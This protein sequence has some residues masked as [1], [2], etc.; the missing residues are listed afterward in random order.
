MRKRIRELWSSFSYWWGRRSLQSRLVAAY[1]FIIL[2]PSLLVSVF[3]FRTINNTYVRDAVDKNNY[4][5]QMEKLH[6]VNQI[7]VMERAAQI[8]YSDSAV[9]SYLSNESA[10]TLG[11]LVDFNNTTFIN[12]SR[13]QLNNPG[14]EH[15]RLYSNNES[16][17][18]IWPI[19]L[20]EDRVYEEPWY[21]EALKLEERE[22]WV[23]QSNDPDVMQRYTNLL[24]EGQPKV[25]LLRAI[26]IPAGH[27][28]GMIQVDMMLNNFTPKTYTDVR[29]NQSQ[30][31]I[32]DSG[33]RL[34]TRS[35]NSFTE[36]Y[37]QLEKAITERLKHYGETGEWD[38]HYKENG[39]SFMLIHTPLERIGASL[40]NVVSM[41]DVMKHI[42]QTRNLLIG[43][44]IG[45]IFLVTLIAYVMN[46]FILKK[47]RLLTETMK[48]VRKG[49]TYTGLSIRGGGEVGELAHHFNKL[50]NTINTLVAQA[51]HKQALTKEAELRTLHNQIDAHFLYNTLEN[52]KML[53]EI[54]DQRTI[55]D[56]LTWLGGM[57]R[58]NFKWTG[59]YVKLRDEIRHIQNYIEIMNIRFEHPIH[60]ELNI[61]QVYMEVEVLKMSLQPI[62][63]N[64]VKHAWNNG[65]DEPEGRSIRI[66]VTESEGELFILIGDNG[67]GLTPERLAALHENIYAKE[68]QSTE[69]SGKGSAGYKAG[70][71]GLRNVHQRL[72]LFYGD[73]YGLELQSEPGRWTTVFMTLPKVLLTGDKR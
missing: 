6:I 38:I 5:L 12:L 36:N 59:E 70:G 51:V 20:R 1:I 69:F 46:A 53:A 33:M 32:A 58:Y 24:T 44:N 49:E 67:C 52:I 61:D 50:M 27:H 54:E 17:Y 57:M 60:L 55:S 35:D 34:F 16:M 18:E 26:S 14:I 41:E 64:S 30:M 40:I 29:D 39:S 63:E 2:G 37:T 8:A 56:A 23:F 19:I 31:F 62:V 43:A 47:L 13:I 3:S 21:Q 11:E 48:K 68:E 10:L 7:E 71:I 45:F 28:V 22:L 15:L 42:S 4:L 66:D 9:R 72:Q 65:G 25:S 73:A